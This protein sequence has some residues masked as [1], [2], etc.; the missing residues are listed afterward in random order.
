MRI[1]YRAHQPAAFA[2]CN[3]PRDRFSVGNCLTENELVHSAIAAVALVDSQVQNR[4]RFGWWE[5][6]RVQAVRTCRQLFRIRLT[7]HIC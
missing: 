7:N 3:L 4:A 2:S 5:V 1:D 6:G